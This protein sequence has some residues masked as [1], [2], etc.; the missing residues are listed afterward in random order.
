MRLNSAAVKRKF[1]ITANFLT[2]AITVCQLLLS[3]QAKE[4]TLAD[5]LLMC[6]AGLRNRIR[7]QRFLV[8]VGFLRK[9]GVG[10]GFFILLRSPIESFFTLHT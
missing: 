7:G 2:Y 3:S 8:G 1:L 4:L 5:T 10:I 9:V 6:V